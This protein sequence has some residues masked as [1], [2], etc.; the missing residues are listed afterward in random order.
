LLPAAADTAWRPTGAMSTPRRDHASVL[1]PNAKILVA[2]YLTNS[3]E[4]YDPNTGQFT[5]A[6]RM[7]FLHGQGLTA[8]VLK[9]GTVLIVGGTDAPSGVEL[10]D[11]VSGRFSVTGSTAFPHSYHTATLLADGRVLVA[12]GL[13]AG[14]SS[15]AAE[16]YDPVAGQF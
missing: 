16:I 2:G 14:Q 13:N 9:N 5:P 6:G 10:Y 11:P 7:Q 15:R 3:A 12:G 4:L 8:T 1:L